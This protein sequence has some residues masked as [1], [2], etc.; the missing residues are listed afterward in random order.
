MTIPKKFSIKIKINP[1]KNKLLFIFFFLVFIPTQNIFAEIIKD[2]IYNYSLDI[3]AGFELDDI[4]PDG[5]SYLFTHP[6]IPV[7]LAIKIYDKQNIQSS[8]YALE[9]SLS[10]MNASYSIDDFYWNNSFCAISDFAFHLDKDYA[11]WA[12][13]APLKMKDCY[14]TLLCFATSKERQACDQFIMSTLNSLCTSDDLYSTPGIIVSY[15]FPK[16]GDKDIKL[17]IG[18]TKIFTTLDNVDVDASNFVIDLEFSVLKLYSKHSFWKE[19]W[20]RYYRLIYR[21][22]YGRIEKAISDIYDEIYPIAK[23]KN[24]SNPDL[25]FAQMILSWVQDF[26]YTRNNQNTNSSDFT[27]L[28]AMLCGEGNDC[29]SRSLLVCMFMRSMGY[30]SILLISPEYSHAMAAVEIDGLGQKYIPDGTD[31]EFLMGETT[32]KVTWGT[33]A[34]IHSDRTKWIPVYLP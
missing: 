27:S 31:K 15:A 26:D 34:K 10:K 24:P 8:P 11:G 5:L 16:E 30:E 22:S 29:D 18:N 7:Q 1:I 28:P 33:I 23:N 25:Q 17:N 12:I 3:P 2:N 19:A 6:N 9:T 14:I 20:Q 4:S 21:D 13:A 32:A